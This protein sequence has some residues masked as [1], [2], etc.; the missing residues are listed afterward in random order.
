MSSRECLCLFFLSSPY[1]LY[2]LLFFFFFSSIPHSAYSMSICLMSPVKGSPLPSGRNPTSSWQSDPSEDADDDEEL[3]VSET[4]EGGVATLEIAVSTWPRRREKRKE[5][6]AMGDRS[7]DDGDGDNDFDND[8][9][10]DVNSPVRLILYRSPPCPHLQRHPA[11]A[12]GYLHSLPPHLVLRVVDHR[13]AWH[14]IVSRVAIGGDERRSKPQLADVGLLTLHREAETAA[15]QCQV[16]P[17]DCDCDQC[18]C[19]GGSRC[20]S[21]SHLR[22]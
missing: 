16:V 8:V 10:N 21:Q 7:R 17:P 1:F 11:L 12:H 13:Y 15:A 22:A 3:V 6:W 19:C 5:R 20:S 2:F 18:L 4:I 14:R 9:D